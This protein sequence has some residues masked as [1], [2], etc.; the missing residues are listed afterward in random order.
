MSIPKSGSNSFLSNVEVSHAVGAAYG[1][2]N[3]DL[4][5]PGMLIN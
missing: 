5:M 4:G 3:T 2:V 1:V